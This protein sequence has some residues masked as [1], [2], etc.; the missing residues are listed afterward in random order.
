MGEDFISE[1]EKKVID[2]GAFE[3]KSVMIC[4]PTN[5]G[6]S[7]IAQELLVQ[8]LEE[9][10]IG[11]TSVY[12]CPYKALAEEIAFS[13]EEMI[14]T[15]IQEV[16]ENGDISSLRH[17]RPILSTGDY[18]EPVDF[19]TVP[20]LVATYEK[21]A[22]LISKRRDFRP[23]VVIA[24]EV[25]LIGDET[26][27]A[28]AEFL[29]SSLAE[30]ESLGQSVLFYP[31]SAVMGNAKQIADWLNLPLVQGDDNDR[32]VP[33]TIKPPLVHDGD[34]A[35]TFIRKT[36]AAEVKNKRQVLV[37]DP[38]A[39]ANSERRAEGL[40]DTVAKLLTRE[41]K[42]TAGSIA[43][44]LLQIVPYLRP[45]ADLV[46]NGVAYHHAGLD[47]EARRLIE[48]DVKMGSDLDQ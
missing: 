47:L 39:R 9:Q 10:E 45:L 7:Y 23:Y 35:T 25:Q 27:G 17:R 14:N 19:S 8:Y 37:L 29:I 15:R 41:E 48:R 43:N 33:L 42:K 6:K 21:F 46:R 36:V 12:L 4:A 38:S 40:K 30:G 32:F 16:E 44:Q 3:G 2:S 22:S 28:R 13:L 24:D 11:Y 20:L 5:T 1:L 26:R 31:L 18:S 34:A